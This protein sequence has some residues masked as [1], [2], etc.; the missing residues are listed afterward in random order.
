MKWTYLR[1]LL[2][3]AIV[4]FGSCDSTRIQT[5]TEEKVTVIEETEYV[6][7]H[8]DG[9]GSTPQWGGI[10]VRVGIIGDSISTFSGWIPNGYVAYYPHSAGAV[11]DLT[12][13][14]QTWW[15]RLIYTLM[16]DAELDMNL[17]FSATCVAK[18]GS[19]SLYD[20]NDFVTRC[21]GFDN[22][23]IVV[24]HGGTNDRGISLGHP[25]PLGEYDYD[26]PADELDRYSFRPAY[27]C[28]VKKITEAWPGVKIVCVIGDCLYQEEYVSLAESIEEIAGHY[29]LPVVKFES[30]LE[31][32]DG[33]HPDSY[34][35]AYMS[36]RIYDV[37][38]EENL[39]YY[40]REGTL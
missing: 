37:M 4:I 32:F 22:P 39:L 21:T 5:V 3:P 27:I 1:L 14:S 31:T 16:P 19:E 29:G 18:T 28:M 30:P 13:V 35:A 7:R 26:T 6:D 36:D 38:E 8:Q 20:R 24:I 23:D 11:S 25:A 34:G 9:T 40:K 15:H 33:V 2:W 17:S 12:D 10:P